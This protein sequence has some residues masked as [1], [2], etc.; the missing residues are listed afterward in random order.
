VICRRPGEN[1]EE[2][3]AWTIEL[4]K[5]GQNLFQFFYEVGAAIS[6]Q[7]NPRVFAF[8]GKDP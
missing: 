3:F 7:L 5:T 6:N 2:A 8:N 4:K 1:N